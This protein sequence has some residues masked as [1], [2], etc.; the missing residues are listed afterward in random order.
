[1]VWVVGG[2]SGRCQN[3]NKQAPQPYHVA[4][5][6]QTVHAN[7]LF[8]KGITN[9]H[10]VL[11]EIWEVDCDYYTLKYLSQILT[12][13]KGRSL[14]T[15][16]CFLFLRF[17]GFNVPHVTLKNP[18]GTLGKFL[19]NEIDIGYYPRRFKEVKIIIFKKPIKLDYS[20]IKV[21]RLIVLFY[22]LNKTLKIVIIKILSD[23]AEDYGLLPD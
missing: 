2:L 21:Y 20:E 9:N 18:F 10:P 23:Y 4:K 17:H 16:K 7:H 1:M 5:T 6:P 8:G 22:T 12:E 14:D 19:F 11:S 3:V 13:K 15:R